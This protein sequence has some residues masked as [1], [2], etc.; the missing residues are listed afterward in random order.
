[1]L[2]RSNLLRAFTKGGFADI[3][4]VHQWNR[5]F[6]A[7]SPSGQRY[8]A[9]ADEIE[10]AVKF[11]E[12]CGI[13]SET[14]AELRQVDFFTSHEALLLDYEEALT[15]EDSLTGDWYDCS[16]HMLWI[17]E[18]TRQID[19]AHIEFLRGV[20][21][22]IG[23]KVGPNATPEEVLEICETINPDRKPGRLTLIV[24]DRKSVV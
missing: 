18:R 6:V 4:H 2:F 23:C 19:G 9:L 1:M 10:R 15:R 7:D 16:A 21:N 13:T 17:G 8:E 3:S 24:R 11:M 12:A 5:E 22:P 14:L 20:K